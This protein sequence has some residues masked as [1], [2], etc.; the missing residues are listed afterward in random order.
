MYIKHFYIKSSRTSFQHIFENWRFDT[1]CLDGKVPFWLEDSGQSFSL[2]ELPGSRNSNSSLSKKI[3]PQAMFVNSETGWNNAYIQKKDSVNYI[4]K[5]EVSKG[6]KRYLQ[7]WCITV[8][9]KGTIIS[10][11][12]R[13]HTCLVSKL[14]ST[15]SKWGNEI[16]PW[17]KQSH[18]PSTPQSWTYRFGF[19]AIFAMYWYSGMPPHKDPLQKNPTKSW[20][21]Q[22][23]KRLPVPFLVKGFTIGS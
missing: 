15:L 4:L 23:E 5:M 13:S 10:C 18:P 19:P 2:L 20:G 8:M 1:W 22:W 9:Y 17:E 11:S 16:P 3:A 6:N 12:F 7:L 14:P 21:F